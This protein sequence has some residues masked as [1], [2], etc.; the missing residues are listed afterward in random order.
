[1]TCIPNSF[2]SIECPKTIG[3]LNSCLLAVSRSNE[4]PPLLDTVSG[5]QLNAH[6]EVWTDEVSEVLVEWFPLMLSIELLGIL[7]WHLSH[8]NIPN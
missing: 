7:E 8:L 2:C 3:S 1:M 5:N 6:N 4:V